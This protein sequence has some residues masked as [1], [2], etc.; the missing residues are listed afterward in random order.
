MKTMFSCIHFPVWSYPQNNENTVFYTSKL[1]VL[2]GMHYAAL[3]LYSLFNQSFI[4]SSLWD[5]DKSS[6]IPH[7]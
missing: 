5:T 3:S 7:L 4:F 6:S 1:Y 2:T